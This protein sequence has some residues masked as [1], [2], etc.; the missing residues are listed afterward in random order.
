MLSITPD[1]CARGCVSPLPCETVNDFASGRTTIH[2]GTPMW[3][4]PVTLPTRVMPTARKILRTLS[5]VA[6]TCEARIVPPRSIAAVCAVASGMRLVR[7]TY[8]RGARSAVARIG[9]LQADEE[10]R[11]P[12]TFRDVGKG[13][14]AACCRGGNPITEPSRSLCDLLAQTLC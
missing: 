13:A 6:P 9:A 11:S 12:M 1:A 8:L 5:K 10:D 14:A 4:R 7:P 3:S 2:V